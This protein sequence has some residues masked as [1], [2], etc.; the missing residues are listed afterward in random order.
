MYHG[1]GKRGIPHMTG[2]VA[3]DPRS[4]SDPE[5]LDAQRY[6]RQKKQDVP[7]NGRLL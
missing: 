1:I 5:H 4:L 2:D 7:V 3:H 6:G